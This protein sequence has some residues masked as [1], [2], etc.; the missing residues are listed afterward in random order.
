[1][2]NNLHTQT[3]EIEHTQSPQIEVETFPDDTSHI[4]NDSQV[5]DFK[6]DTPL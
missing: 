6:G 1:M 2:H 4:N 3:N 5:I